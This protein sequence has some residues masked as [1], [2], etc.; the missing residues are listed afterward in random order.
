MATPKTVQM[1]FITKLILQTANMKETQKR[2]TLS[3]RSLEMS[4]TTM[5]PF[6]LS[7]SL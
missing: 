7:L 6:S 3:L 1:T 2:F 5:I 4:F